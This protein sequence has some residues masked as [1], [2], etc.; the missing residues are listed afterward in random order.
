MQGA[1]VLSLVRE[2]RSHM[3]H[4]TAKKYKQTNKNFFKKGNLISSVQFS[5][6]VVSNSLRPHELQH[7]RPPCPSPTP[8]VHSSDLAWRIPWTGEPGGLPSMGLR[9]VGHDWSDLAAE[10]E[11]KEKGPEKILGDIIAEKFP[12]MGKEI[13][14]QV[15]EVQSLQQDKPWEE[16]TETHSNQDDES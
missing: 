16:H 14:N 7:A 12:N 4:N 2:L 11:E 13:V 8:G 3:L 15:Q 1:W 10:G 9:R 5:R 6:S